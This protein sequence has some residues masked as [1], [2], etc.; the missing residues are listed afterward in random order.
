MIAG[1]R[2]W[3]AGAV[4]PDV[5]FIFFRTLGEDQAIEMLKEGA[6][7]YVLKQ[8]MSRFVPAI[9]RAPGKRPRNRPAANRPKRTSA[10]RNGSPKRPTRPRANS[11]PT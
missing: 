5:P 8:R 1:K 2:Y 9:Y 6:S 11:W 4:A 7:D 10:N 3:Q